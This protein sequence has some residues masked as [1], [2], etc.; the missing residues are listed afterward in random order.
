MVKKSEKAGDIIYG[1]PHI[2]LIPG[3]TSLIWHRVPSAQGSP[4]MSQGNPSGRAHTGPQLLRHPQWSYCPG[5]TCP[6]AQQFGNSTAWKDHFFN[7]IPAYRGPHT[8]AVPTY[9]NVCA[10]TQ[11]C[12]QIYHKFQLWCTRDNLS[13][14]N[15]T[16]WKDHF[17]IA[18]T[19]KP[20]D[21]QTLQVA[22]ALVFIKFYGFEQHKFY[23][24]AELI[25]DG[26]IKIHVLSNYWS[27]NNNW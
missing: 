12:C 5:T 16:A 21:T 15:Y 22:D 17:F 18:T 14:G 7:A 23:W 10:L 24:V 4:P 27:M 1:Q 11:D 3:K 26:F 25:I 6:L 2:V 9:A 13:A 20:W 8:C 19:V